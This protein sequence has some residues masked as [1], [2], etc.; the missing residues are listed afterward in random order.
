MG[1]NLRLRTGMKPVR[2][3]K[4]LKI[5]IVFMLFVIMNAV[6]ISIFDYMILYYKGVPVFLYKL[7]Y[8]LVFEIIVLALISRIRLKLPILLIYIAQSIYIF[9]YLSY[10]SYFHSYLH[11][12][13]ASSLMTESVGPITHFS[14]PVNIN[15]LVMLVDVPF[16][17]YY[18][19]KYRK[20]NT[21]LKQFTRLRLSVLGACIT[22]L[23][24]FEGINGMNNSSIFQMGNHFYSTEP[25]IVEKY[26]T[27]AN[28]LCDI[29]FNYG[30]NSLIKAF[31]YGKPIT[32]NKEKEIQ[33]NII[34]IQVE[35][36]DA[37]VINQ[38]VNGK[39]IAPFLH[40]LSTESIYYPYMMSYHK[41]GG[42][43]DSEFSILSSIEP[44][45][46]YPSIKLSKY[47]YPNSIVR[48][49]KAG[50]YRAYAFHGNIG[51]FYSRDTAFRKIGFDA[52]YDIDKM[53]LKNEGWGAPDGEVFQYA[54]NQI[55]KESGKGPVFSYIITM[56]SHMPFESASHYYHNT[57]YDQIQETKVR[58]YFNSISYVDQSIQ[59]F[60]NQVRMKMPNTYIFIWGDH[61]P[62]ITADE[63]KQASYTSFDKYFEFVPFLLSTPDK[64]TYKSVDKA[65]CFLDLA[66]TFLDAAGIAYQYRTDGDDLLKDQFVP[67]NI[68][69]K[70]GTYTRTE[71]YKQISRATSD[72]IN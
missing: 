20:I 14:I 37:N 56:T 6:K 59:S 60:V 3:D 38:K 48:V 12:F 13:Q 15:M 4:P 62:A 68:P 25:K 26:G 23:L 39:Y 30:G 10:F 35:S 42:T 31:Q 61:T 50:G 28:N 57:D 19:V 33:P 21:L 36:M 63:Y 51:A 43:S 9:A 58:N 7:C 8:T 52:F 29:V 2:E 67:T 40:K 72:K 5:F 11:L 1:E 71:L 53:G 18:M 49:L 54:L 24:L 55:E 41:A 22:I 46:D 32:S 27:I 66:P 64:K 47:K 34:G 69:F 45:S 70:L 16:F 17:I 44:L 65:A